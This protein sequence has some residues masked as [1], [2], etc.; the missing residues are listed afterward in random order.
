MKADGDACA[1]YRFFDA[2]G[3]LLYVGI[4]ISAFR[5]TAE[6]SRG[7]PWFDAIAQMTIERFDSRAKA[8]SAER[9]AIL[10]EKPKHNVVHGWSRT[11]PNI[12]PMT[13]AA[14][15]ELRHAMTVTSADLGGS[16]AT[17][18]DELLDKQPGR[19]IKEALLPAYGLSVAETARRIGVDRAGFHNTLTGKY[20][21]S[22]DLA[23]KLGALMRDEVADFLIAYQAAYDLA[24]ERDKRESYKA[25][26]ERMVLPAEVEAA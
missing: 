7:S 5:R 12:Y 4:S 20:D 22:R 13:G 6:H 17:I 10:T 16:V 1:L 26:I 23:Y 19:F 25:K 18:R 14:L 24:R 15:R 11:L 8:L 3:E 2:S 21:V 9:I